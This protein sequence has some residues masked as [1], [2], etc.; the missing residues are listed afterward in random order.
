MGN[1]RANKNA[2]RA[3]RSSLLPRFFLRSAK[4]QANAFSTEGNESF[5]EV[6]NTSH[7]VLVYEA[8]DN[9]SP[10]TLLKEIDLA[11]EDQTDTRAMLEKQMEATFKL[12]KARYSGGSEIGAILSMRRVHRNIKIKAYVSAARFQ[13]VQ[14]RKEAETEME[15]NT[16]DVSE[17]HAN[18]KQV[19]STLNVAIIDVLQNKWLPSDEALLR[20]VREMMES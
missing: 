10:A 17:R 15:T 1:S 2:V 14:I 5:T 3:S 9:I 4:S 16:L 8:N 20:E 7:S 13:L 18:M 11:I 19:I 6:S 12:A